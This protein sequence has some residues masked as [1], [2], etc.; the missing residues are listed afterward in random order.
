MKVNRISYILF[1][2]MLQLS[3]FAYAQSADR[4][5]ILSKKILDNGEITTVKYIDGLG[6]TVEVVGNGLGGNG[7]TV[8]N[9][10]KYDELDM[11]TENWNNFVCSG[12]SLDFID[13]SSAASLLENTYDGDKYGFTKT[14]Y[15][16]FGD[17]I[18][19]Q[20]A[21][22]AWYENDKKRTVSYFAN[23]DADKVKIYQADDENQKLV[24]TKMFFPAGHLNKIALTDEDGKMVYIFKDKNGKVVLVR[25]SNS[26]D[27]YYVYNTVG[28]LRYVLSPE[29]Q[30]ANHKEQAEYDK[31]HSSK[32]NVNYKAKYAYEYRYDE[33]GR[34]V[35][36]ILPGSEYIQYWYD[37]ADRLTYMRD[38]NL[39][40]KGLYRFMFYD[41]LGR[42]AVQGVCES[43][44]YGFNGQNAMP[45]A[46]FGKT[47][48]KYQIGGYGISGA[49]MNKFAAEVVN[50]YDNYDYLATE[51]FKKSNWQ[52][53]MASASG[54]CAV[55]LPTGSIVRTS[56]YKYLY[57]SVYYDAK[58]RVVR[59]FG[60]HLDG[61]MQEA[62]MSYTFTNNPKVVSTTEYNANGDVEGSAEYTYAYNQYNDKLQ[63]IDL[64]MNGEESAHRIAE[65]TYDD[66]G[67]LLKVRRSG[68]AGDVD[69][70]YN[71]RNWVT[72]ISSK[73]FSE[74][75][76]YT[77]GIGTPCYNGNISSMQWQNGA[78]AAKSGYKFSYDGL[79]R[80]TSA[81]YGEGDDMS[82]NADRFSEKGITYNANGSIYRMKRY[83]MLNDGSYGLVDDLKIKL[84]GNALYG[85]TDYAAE[86]NYKGS[87]NFADADGAGQE[88]WFNGNGSLSADA[89]KGIARIDYDNYGCPRKIVFTNGNTTEYVYSSTGEKLRTTHKTAIDG[90][91]VALNGK[92]NLNDDDFLSEDKTDYHGSFIYENGKLDKVLYPGGYVQK[93]TYYASASAKTRVADAGVSENAENTDNGD[94]EDSSEANCRP[95]RPFSIWDLL[96]EDEDLK[97]TYHYYT[98]DHLGNNRVVVGENGIV[99]QV[100]NYYPFGGVFSTTAYNSGDDLQPYKY[101][102]KELDRTHGLDWYDYGARNYDAFLP[103]FTSL[104][105]LCE[106][107]YHISPYV[108]CANNPMR[109]IDPDGRYFTDKSIDVLKEFMSYLQMQLRQ[110]GEKMNKA[111]G[112]KL[113]KLEQKYKETYERNQRIF[114]EIYQLA[115]SDQ[116]YSIGYGNDYCTA[117]IT[118][119]AGAFRGGRYD[120]RIADGY[121]TNER[122]GVIGHEL[123]HAFQ[124]EKG[125]LSSGYKYKG[126]ETFYDKTDEY[127]ALQRQSEITGKTERLDMNLDNYRGLSDDRKS[128][129]GYFD[130]IF[131]FSNSD[132]VLQEYAEKNKIVF[133][134]RNKTYMG[135]K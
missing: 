121:S 15:N 124:F 57:G 30:Y 1:V 134:Y 44:D 22:A 33:R 93:N 42:L 50:Y 4:N 3:D 28:Q 94:N 83:G 120:I 72:S 29:Y 135:L 20:G 47:G 90:I 99:K 122:M 79:N 116:A 119:S 41:R 92:D 101:N 16:I 102:G 108:Y 123:K 9:Y 70:A 48:V 67:R 51:M 88:Y 19:M 18:S 26:N 55:G 10:T 53:K 84:D 64:R 23:D 35:K 104:D 132:K 117:D 6:R 111:E 40:E 43:C 130:A 73:E 63:S 105:P 89:N 34:V 133:R 66:L 87:A 11:P 113:E 21:G 7:K 39:R 27:T 17:L 46:E 31:N 112:E 129:R 49:T 76:H 80:L 61:G 8:A 37:K 110:I 131:M 91:T 54:A 95:R 52:Q 78:S 100:T 77:D 62:N 98:Q 114:N 74:T 71:I 56:N 82:Q 128:A 2:L 75:L 69:Y 14:E 58:G 24:N 59:T 127:E 60:T 115:S 126:G 86:T 12:N 125:E 38:A 96:M 25:R 13:E 5:Y 65:N 118:M 81:I 45:K 68:S 97:Y 32:D 107:Y 106:K 103:M 109:F 85:I 36:K